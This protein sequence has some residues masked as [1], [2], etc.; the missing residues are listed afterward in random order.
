MPAGQGLAIISLSLPHAGFHRLYVMGCCRPMLI[1]AGMGPGL[2]GLAWPRL[3]SGALEQTERSCEGQQTAKT[4]QRALS[5]SGRRTSSPHILRSAG[6]WV[7]NQPDLRSRFFWRAVID[8]YDLI[9]VRCCV[10][11]IGRDLGRTT[12]SF[13]LAF[14]FAESKLRVEVLYRPHTQTPNQHHIG[15]SYWRSPFLTQ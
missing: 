3:F 4:P 9:A 11:I 13:H 15:S 12:F 10:K 14:G 5:G 6:Y 2:V 8:C 7:P 1:V